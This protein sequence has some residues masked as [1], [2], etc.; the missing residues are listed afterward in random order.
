MSREEILDD[1]H[2][3][4][5]ENHELEKFIDSIREYYKTH[6]FKGAKFFDCNASISEEPTNQLPPHCLDC[7]IN[8]GDFECDRIYCR[9]G[10]R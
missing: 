3:P 6:E 5:Q 4:Q 7:I 10:E 9:K 1:L 8:G 2:E